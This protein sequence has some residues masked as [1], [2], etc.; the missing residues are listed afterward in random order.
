MWCL[1]LRELLEARNR[2]N[3]RAIGRLSSLKVRQSSWSESLG[4]WE[5]ECLKIGRLE[6][7]KVFET[8]KSESFKYLKVLKCK[9]LANLRYIRLT[10]SKRYVSSRLPILRQQSLKERN[11]MSL[12]TY[13][14][15]DITITIT[16]WRCMTKR[17]HSRAVL[18]KCIASSLELRVLRNSTL[19]NLLVNGGKIEKGKKA[20]D[21]DRSR[22]VFAWEISDGN[23][24][25]GNYE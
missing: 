12:R 22:E 14:R 6:N 11:V 24:F 10:L 15:I 2:R 3:W 23:F 19:C 5:S 9:S 21:G 18:A 4:I 8:L 16:R 17:N 13:N 20:N 7:S 1:E 25:L